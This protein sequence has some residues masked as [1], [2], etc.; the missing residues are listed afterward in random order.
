MIMCLPR[1]SAVDYFRALRG[2]YPGRYTLS[3]S[4]LFVPGVCTA[5]P[6]ASWFAAVRD[7]R[8]GAACLRWRILGVQ[9]RAAEH[10]EDR[11]QQVKL[12]ARCRILPLPRDVAI[13]IEQLH[14]SDGKRA[15]E[16]EGFA[17]TLLGVW[18]LLEQT[19]SSCRSGPAVH[20]GAAPSRSFYLIATVEGQACLLQGQVSGRAER[21]DS[22]ASL[23]YPVDISYP[24]LRVVA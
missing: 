7:G 12:L 13:H 19:C 14:H 5:L 6:S 8:V 10:K 21:R 17:L 16:S 18:L 3:W 15:V 9:V 20:V 4:G 11:N 2:P 23:P 24:T 1:R 22:S